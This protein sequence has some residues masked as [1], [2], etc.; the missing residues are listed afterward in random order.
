M[1]QSSIMACSKHH[2]PE[3]L[4]IHNP[5]SVFTRFESDFS[6]KFH[7]LKAWESPLPLD[8]F[9]TTHARSVRSMFSYFNFTQVNADLLRL[10]PALE[11][12]VTPTVGVN[13]IDLTECRRR[14]I[15]VAN[16]GAAYSED[17]ADC[18]VGL[19]IDVHRRLSAADRY[20]RQRL[21]G[22]GTPDD[23]RNYPLTGRKLGGK[24]VGIV[25]LGSIGYEVAKRLEA[26]GCSIS[27]NSRREKPC[28]SYPFYSDVCELAANNDSLIIC[29]ALTDQTHHLIN[30]QVLSAL[31][32]EGVIV[33]VGRGAVIDEKELVRCLVHGEIRGAGLDVFEDEPHVPKVLFGL[34]NVVLSPH[35]AAFTP[36]SFQT[37]SDVMVANLEAFFSDQPLLTSFIDD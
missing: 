29:C 34:D 16:A 36:E 3:L 12:V 32:R 4:V 8:Q 1:N 30:K 19:F 25:G 7:I 31:G 17:V 11:L 27:Y 15:S 23:R 20:I 18:A 9:L 22:I 14:G 10:L 26:F 13:H 28:V 21:W 35:I 37:V 6:I 2:L 5:Y 33:N 24:R